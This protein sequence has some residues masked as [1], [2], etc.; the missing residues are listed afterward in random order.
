MAL[1]ATF[2]LVPVHIK[3][4]G[5]DG[6][7]AKGSVT[8]ET[9]LPIRNFPDKVIIGPA[10][11]LTANLTNG[12]ATI[13][14]PSTND[15][16]NIPVGWSYT[17]KVAT[18]VWSDTITGV[19]VPFTLAT[20][21]FYE[22]VPPPTVAPAQAD[23]YLPLTG[24]AVAGNLTV[25]GNL[26]VAG[27][28]TGLSKASIGLGNAD[29]TSDAG[30][31]V[32]TATATA[33]GLKTDKK[34]DVGSIQRYNDVF[35]WFAVGSS[36]AG[37]IVVRTNIVLGTPTSMLGFD[38]VIDQ[39]NGNVTHG[40]L[41]F[42]SFNAVGPGGTPG[43]AFAGAWVYSGTQDTGVRLAKDAGGK[44]C[45]IF[46]KATAWAYPG[47][48]FTEARVRFGAQADTVFAGWTASAVD[49]AAI[50]TE[51]GAEIS[52]PTTQRNL[53]TALDAKLSLAGGTLTGKMTTAIGATGA[54][55]MRIPHGVAPSAPLSGD[56]WTTNN[57]VYARINGVTR[58]VDTKL[59]YANALDFGFAGDNFTDNLPAWIAMIN[60]INTVGGNL[61][62]QFPEGEFKVG[63]A[64]GVP[65]ITASNVRIQGVGP[66]ATNLR[67]TSGVYWNLLGTTGLP[68]SDFAVDDLT[69][70]YAVPDTANPTLRGKIS[71]WHTFQNVRFTGGATFAELGGLALADWSYNLRLRNCTVRIANA[72][73]PFIRL[74]GGAGLYWDTFDNVG[75]M[76]SVAPT[77]DRVSTMNTL[78]GTNAVDIVGHWDT[79]EMS[80]FAEKLYRVLN[81]EGDGTILFNIRLK[82]SVCDYI[83]DSV[84][85]VDLGGTTF[86]SLHTVSIDNVYGVTWEGPAFYF[87]SKANASISS[88]SF[89]N[90]YT[91][92]TGKQA[93]YFDVDGGPG[94]RKFVVNGCKFIGT[95]RMS[96]SYP[97]MEID[98][99]EQLVMTGNRIGGNDT[100]ANVSWGVDRGLKLGA[101]TGEYNISG[102]VCEAYDIP[103][104]TTPVGGSSSKRRRVINNVFGGSVSAI[105]YAGLSTSAPF[106]KPATT[107]DW[108][109][110]TP[111]DVEVFIGG[112]SVTAIKM[113]GVTLPILQG[114]LTLE[115]GH[116]YSI[117]YTDGAN[118][119]VA[120][121]VKQ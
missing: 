3:I 77:F 47:L 114:S 84:V 18:D 113:D 79:V 98:A 26:D 30:K 42:Y 72:G 68:V 37:S 51:F 23:Y 67:L 82:D 102:N 59:Q 95:G 85:Y 46:D 88:V 78:P 53:F 38:I 31:P 74:I 118:A 76:T 93:F 106:T 57:G 9:S 50:T 52:V 63:A 71:A 56:I 111:Y 2:N 34:L 97:A 61:H 80:V 17:V 15:P 8:W 107:V 33:L 16:D 20:L 29:N 41:N 66:D 101:V 112:S 1:P 75:H 58:S 4:V 87:R 73:K 108:Y 81:I 62:I 116:Y 25:S 96:D 103:I 99:V 19:Q 36:V 86:S 45:I 120:Y 40:E 94:M 90:V 32:S 89:N 55:P 64:V 35:H 119:N 7:P 70:T 10:K 24:G 27:G 54:A 121:S 49:P 115:P 11:K 12:E 22:I 69:I 109:N 117:T 28:L 21:E 6:S 92:F 91:P 105:N 65:T 13:D 100:T 5:L 39:L 14:I 104:P 48:R 43:Y 44:L 60:H 83:R 110:V